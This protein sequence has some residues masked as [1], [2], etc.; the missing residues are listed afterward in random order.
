MSKLHSTLLNLPLF[1]FTPSTIKFLT[2]CL[3]VS[4]LFH[5]TPIDNDK[6]ENLSKEGEKPQRA[7]SRVPS[8]TLFY[9]FCN[10]MIAENKKV[11]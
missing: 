8:T 4:I 5:I 10:K 3:K 11:G 1:Y 7:S 9:L 2:L 6:F